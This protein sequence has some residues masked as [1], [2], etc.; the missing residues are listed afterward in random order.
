MLTSQGGWLKSRGIWE[1]PAVDFVGGKIL[2]IEAWRHL[3]TMGRDHYVQVVYKG[4]L[5]PFGHRASLIKVTERKIQPNTVGLIAAFSRQR[6]YIVVRQTKKEFPAFGHPFD[7]RAFPWRIV[8]IM[9]TVTPSLDDPETETGFNQSMFWPSIGGVPFEFVCKLIDQDGRETIAPVPFLFVDNQVAFNRS[10]SEDAR[11]NYNLGTPQILARRDRDFRGQKIAFAKSNQPGD[12]QYDTNRITFKV[13]FPLDLTDPQHQCLYIKG[14]PFFYP[15]VESAK[16]NPA[17]V[18][19]ITGNATPVK[20]QYTAGYLANGFDPN[21]N[22]GEVFFEVASDS[23]LALNFGGSGKADQAGGVITPNMNIVGFSRKNGPVGGGGRPGTP[24]HVRTLGLQTAATSSAIARIQNGEF[25]PLD[26]FGGALEKAKILGGISLWDII[27]PLAAGAISNLGDAP[28]ILEETLYPAIQRL[29]EIE[30]AIVALLGDLHEGVTQKLSAEIQEVRDSFAH[31]NTSQLDLAGQAR[32]I[33]SL[34][35]LVDRMNAILQDPN[36]LI[37]DAF[38]GLAAVFT[39]YESAVRASV[40]QIL[41]EWTRLY[42][43]DLALIE[44]KLTDLVLTGLKYET[45][46]RSYVQEA[47][48]VVAE[49]RAQIKTIVDLANDPME[50]AKAIGPLLAADRNTRSRQPR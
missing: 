37:E 19:R 14:Q 12:T 30:A 32:F 23:S 5:L 36:L 11:R 17:A 45:Q 39:G 26:Y 15:A 38:R 2:T 20:V 21:I 33:R 35:R 50:L 28:K 29:T 27:K 48:N 4:Y 18:R 49:L 47:R 1:P 16:L 41:D 9:T 22:R 10:L 3:A 24:T 43:Q 8:E 13:E 40:Q 42:A 25:D 34:I 31:L 46:I 6:M 7:G 44:N